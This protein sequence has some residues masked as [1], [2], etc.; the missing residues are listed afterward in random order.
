MNHRTRGRR[1]RTA[2]PMKN[3]RP[4]A[5]S[6]HVIKSTTHGRVE[7]KSHTDKTMDA[8]NNQRAKVS[9]K[10]VRAAFKRRA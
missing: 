6:H 4:V 2:N 3:R 1:K 5:K 10:S 7:P 8:N 9:G